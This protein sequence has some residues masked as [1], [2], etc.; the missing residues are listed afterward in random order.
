MGGTL[1]YDRRIHSGCGCVFGNFT[2][3]C[4]YE[5]EKTI[6]AC[7][8]LDFGSLFGYGDMERLAE[9]PPDNGVNAVCR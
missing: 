6:I 4:L 7:S 2:R 1:S 3:I 8:L 9:P 5:T